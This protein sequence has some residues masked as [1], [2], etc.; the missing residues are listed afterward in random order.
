MDKE[1]GLTILTLILI[2]IRVLYDEEL[3]SMPSLGLIS[4]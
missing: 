4:S 3:H 2:E 1:F